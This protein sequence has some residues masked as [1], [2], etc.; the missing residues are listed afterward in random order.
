LGGFPSNAPSGATR[1]VLGGNPYTEIIWTIALL[2]VMHIMLKHTRWGTHTVATGGNF[3][4]AGEVGIKVNRV[5]IVNFIVCS[6]FAGFAG[7]LEA[8]RIGSIDPLAGG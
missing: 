2:I 3:V 1:T 5:R 7:I 6:V 4:G 8:M